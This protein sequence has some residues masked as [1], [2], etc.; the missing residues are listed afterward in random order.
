MAVPSSRGLDIFRDGHV[1]VLLGYHKPL[2]MKL[3]TRRVP[4]ISA[5]RALSILAIR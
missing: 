4:V 1:L 3:R 5:V 2:A